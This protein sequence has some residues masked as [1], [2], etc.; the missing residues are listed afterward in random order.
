M[1]KYANSIF[2]EYL[3]KT[4]FTFQEVDLMGHLIGKRPDYFVDVEDATVYVE[5]KEIDVEEWERKQVDVRNKIER[6]FTGINYG[7][8][9]SPYVD[10]QVWPINKEIDYFA[11][12]VRRVEAENIFTDLRPDYLLMPKYD[13]CLIRGGRI[14]VLYMQDAAGETKYIAVCPETNDSKYPIP[15][16]HFESREIVNIKIDGNII[17]PYEIYSCPPIIIFEKNT[18]PY[19]HLLS[20]CIGGSFSKSDQIRK[21]IDKASSNL[22][23]YKNKGPCVLVLFTKSLVGIDEFELLN[24]IAGTGKIVFPVSKNGH[25]P[26]DDEVRFIRE[27]DGALKP[28]QYTR[29]SAIAILIETSPPSLCVYHNPFAEKPLSMNIFKGERDVQYYFDKKTGG[30]L[31][32]K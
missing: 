18:M 3:Q 5:V 9:Y 28:W 7:C 4:G 32:W 1:S 23:K 2:K 13:Q 17:N 21:K 8:G 16:G 27:N 11:V 12:F 20:I 30:K 19:S 24:A 29:F 14:K 25:K 22:G 10:S 15:F 6:A 26:A 31:I